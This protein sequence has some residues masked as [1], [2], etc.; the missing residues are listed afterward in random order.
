MEGV[1]RIPERYKDQ[2][3]KKKDDDGKKKKKI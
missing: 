2:F 3:K 1:T